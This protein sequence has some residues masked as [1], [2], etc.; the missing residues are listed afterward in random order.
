MIDT[1]TTQTHTY[2]M[3]VYSIW[4]KRIWEYNIIKTTR[5]RLSINSGEAINNYNLLIKGICPQV[6]NRRIQN[7]L[8]SPSDYIIIMHCHC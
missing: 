8:N 6:L 2:M 1:H 7:V 5:L 4:P 3:R